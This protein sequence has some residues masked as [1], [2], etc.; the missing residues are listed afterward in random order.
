MAADAPP[1]VRRTIHD[2][3]G[4]FLAQGILLVIGG[5]AAIVLPQIATVAF[6]IFL[7]WLL[8]IVGA[9]RFISMLSSPRA[10]AYWGSLLFDALMIILGA[11]LVFRPFA[12]VI[13]LTI[14]LLVYF[15]LHCFSSIYLALTVR[16]HTNRWVWLLLSGLLDLALAAL[17]IWGWPGTAVW[18]LGL[19]VGINMLFSGFALIFASL[20]QKAAEA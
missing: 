5:A 3:W 19:F 18:I 6:S 14:A 13:S 12:G 20:G 17:I 8:I 9:V 1:R 16:T 7:G 10:P 4:L 2:Y 15:I 11:I